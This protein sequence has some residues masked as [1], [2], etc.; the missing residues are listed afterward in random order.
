M[1]TVST[2]NI[3]AASIFLEMYVDIPIDIII[4]LKD[5]VIQCIHLLNSADALSVHGIQSNNSMYLKTF[6]GFGQ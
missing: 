5:V 1:L 3:K 4:H 2:L 6:W